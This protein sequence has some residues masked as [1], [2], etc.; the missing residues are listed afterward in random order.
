MSIADIAS[1]FQLTNV[2]MMLFTGLL[3]ASHHLH[4]LCNEMINIV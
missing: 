2:L 1:N 3:F 4:E